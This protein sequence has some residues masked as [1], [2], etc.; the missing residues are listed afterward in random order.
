MQI[1]SVV[2]MYVCIY[3]CIYILKAVF[4]KLG[5]FGKCL[6]TTYDIQINKSSK[7]EARRVN[8]PLYR[9]LCVGT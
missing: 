2:R 9:K 6:T 3:L 4:R 1:A 7:A 5:P 8:E